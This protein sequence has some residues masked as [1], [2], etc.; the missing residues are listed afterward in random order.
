M[1]TPDLDLRL[2]SRPA[3]WK[4]WVCGLLLLAT[5]VNYMDRLTL[6]LTA[7]RI[8]YEFRLDARDYGQLESAFAFA[9]ALGAII[10]GWLADRITVRW[11]YPVA[12]LVWSVAGFATGLVGSFVGLLLCRFLLGFAESGNW[13]CALRTTQQILPPAQRTLGNSI[14]QSGAAIGAVITP[15]IV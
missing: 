8:M 15:L 1:P 3:W 4:W 10:F 6:N 9:F 2:L 12:V 5:M 14:L 7:V 11:L 13:P